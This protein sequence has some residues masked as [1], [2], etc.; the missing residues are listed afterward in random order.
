MTTTIT[1]SLT[2]TTGSLLASLSLSVKFFL[3]QQKEVPMNN[4]G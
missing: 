2:T 3:K 1:A 4:A